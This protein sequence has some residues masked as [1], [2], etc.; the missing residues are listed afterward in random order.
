MCFGWPVGAHLSAFS[1]ADWIAVKA[2]SLAANTQLASG[3]AFSALVS[4]DRNSSGFHSV[5][6][7]MT[8][9]MTPLLSVT[10]CQPLV[11]LTALISVSAPSSSMHLP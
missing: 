8:V 1:S 6:A 11:R 4:P 9:S 5:G 3:W 10:S 7:W 2:K